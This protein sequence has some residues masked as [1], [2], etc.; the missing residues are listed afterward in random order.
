VATAFDDLIERAT[1]CGI[2]VERTD[3]AGIEGLWIPGDRLVLIDQS[4]P[5]GRAV[6]TLAHELEHARCDDET[7]ARHQEIDSHGTIAAGGSLPRHMAW[8]GPTFAVA[9]VLGMVAALLFAVSPGST[10]QGQQ[11]SGGV[12]T[13]DD[14]GTGD[15]DQ[16]EQTSTTSG[17]TGPQYAPRARRRRIPALSSTRRTTAATNPTSTPSPTRET[18]PPAQ[19]PTPGATQE[20]TA[21]PA[22][23]STP[24]HT[25]S[26]PTATP[27]PTDPTEQTAQTSEPPPASPTP[28]HGALCNLLPC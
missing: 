7:R 17:S 25:A 15:Q 19:S 24:T 16:P 28:I 20:P 22:P 23:T 4:L 9:S 21:G 26:P 3:L 8:A 18:R 2:T 13:I 14:P 6:E 10:D 1:K 11:N 5:A 27:S 12:A